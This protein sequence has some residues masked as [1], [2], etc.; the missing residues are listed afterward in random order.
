MRWN[1]IIMTKV[2]IQIPGDLQPFLDGMSQLLLGLGNQIK[3]W[4][5]IESFGCLAGRDLYGNPGG[6]LDA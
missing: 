3:I 4:C 6:G 1:A 2:A 5:G